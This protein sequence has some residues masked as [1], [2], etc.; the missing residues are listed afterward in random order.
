[1]DKFEYRKHSFGELGI[2]FKCENCAVKTGVPYIGEATVLKPASVDIQ[3][4]MCD[5]LNF[6]LI[7]GSLI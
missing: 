2:I 3:L 4:S 6:V 5:A 7:F 1:M